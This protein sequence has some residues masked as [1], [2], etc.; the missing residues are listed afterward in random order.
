MEKVESLGTNQ[1]K[2]LELLSSL[3]ENSDVIQDRLN[4]FEQ[5]SG[6]TR[7]Y[8]TSPLISTRAKV[9]QYFG[10]AKQMCQK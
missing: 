6:A 1:A 7:T 8:D 10:F 5:I 2:I 4:S 9:A 3:K